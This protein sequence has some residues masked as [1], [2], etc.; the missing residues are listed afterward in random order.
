MI[1]GVGF[2]HVLI[3]TIFIFLGTM[4]ANL[5]PLRSFQEGCFPLAIVI[6]IDVKLMCEYED[7]PYMLHEIHNVV[8]ESFGP[9]Y[10]RLRTVCE[11]GDTVL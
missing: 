11:V 2:C 1:D 3:S 4:E 10:V 8:H 9:L 5:Q 6:K 7:F